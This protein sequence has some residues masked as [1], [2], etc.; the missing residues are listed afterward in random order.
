MDLR[1]G[2]RSRTGRSFVPRAG[3]CPTGGRCRCL[4]TI[5]WQPSS[6][7]PPPRSMPVQ[8]SA[9]GS[10]AQLTCPPGRSMPVHDWAAPPV[11]TPS[12]AIDACPRFGGPRFGGTPRQDVLRR[13]RCLSTIG[14][15]I[16]LRL[17]RRDGVDACPQLSRPRLSPRSTGHSPGSRRPRR[18]PLGRPDNLPAAPPRR[19]SD[20]RLPRRDRVDA[21]PK[22]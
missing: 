5:R 14:A 17:P 4:S 21:C 12:A 7:R 3:F 6:G 11:R 13:D 16:G 9:T 22:W 8:D 20:A 15:T 10:A 1:A 18:R 19:P 2:R